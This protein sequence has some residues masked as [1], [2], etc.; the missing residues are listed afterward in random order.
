MSVSE[1]MI[2][3]VQCIIYI[4]GGDCKGNKRRITV[5]KYEN[6]NRNQQTCCGTGKMAGLLSEAVIQTYL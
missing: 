6:Q 2:H 4:I 3:C 5:F 1:V